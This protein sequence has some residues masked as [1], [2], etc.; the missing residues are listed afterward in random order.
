MARATLTTMMRPLLAGAV[1]LGSV[2]Y[3]YATSRPFCS[4]QPRSFWL[5]ALEVELYLK[6]LGLKMLRLR[7]DDDRCYAVVARDSLGQFRDVIMNPV[8]AEVVRL[9]PRL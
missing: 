4:Y 8:T 5:S 7:I 9:A 6:Q 3:L 1:I 2:G